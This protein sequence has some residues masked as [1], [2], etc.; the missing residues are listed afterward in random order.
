VSKD[1]LTTENNSKIL[2]LVVDDDIRILGFLRPSLKLAGYDVITATGGEEGLR[3][4][5]L[6]KPDIMILDILMTPMNGFEVL[7]KLRVTSELPVI[8]ISAHASA[9]EKAFSFGASDFLGKPFVPNELV[10]RI[11][12]LLNQIK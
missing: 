12:A 10:M 6:E 4:V 9:A 11:K 2:V 3:L 5:D 1:A 8:A 7:R